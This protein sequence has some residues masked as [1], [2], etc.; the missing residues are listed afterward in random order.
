MGAKSNFARA[1]G[2]IG[3]LLLLVAFVRATGPVSPA[4]DSER[5]SYEP[6]VIAAATEPSE[7]RDSNSSAG[8][9][10]SPG[11]S[12]AIDPVEHASRSR[13]GY[14]NA[15]E[16]Y[17][18]LSRYPP[19]TRR[20]SADAFDLLNPGAR[21]ERRMALP[22]GRDNPDRDWEV[23]LTADRYLV[24]G[25]EPVIV[26]LELWKDGK[27]IQPRSVYMTAEIQRAG[28]GA[29]SI[30]ELEINRAGGSVSAEF[31]PNDYWSD[32]AGAVRVTV[33]F[34]AR[35]LPEQS[36]Q[37]DFYFTGENR[38]P[39]RFTGAHRD[40]LDAGDLVFD[41]GLSV[42]RP[43]RYFIEGNLYDSSGEAFGWARYEGDIADG[44]TSVPLRFAGLLFHD[45]DK[46][47]LF[48][49]RQVRGRRI[50]PRSIPAREDMADLDAEVK[51]AASYRLADFNG[52]ENDSPRRRRMIAMYE[53]AMNRGVE[54]TRPEYSD[55]QH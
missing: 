44:V 35:E 10:G 30:V 20:I 53:D 41:L 16:H 49:L 11:R 25:A 54:L 48:S 1:A 19:G 24:R 37:L 31:L 18:A 14:D 23:L 2:F 32:R 29:G 43:G 28:E 33:N 27:Q 36:G 3:A 8:A 12:V 38:I 26:S 4:Q 40:R 34:D 5:K 21:H 45:A 9:S 46:A 47:G 22:N 42:R 55:V 52:D 13:A 15:L 51:T 17:K 39:A 6:Q 50:Q 7:A